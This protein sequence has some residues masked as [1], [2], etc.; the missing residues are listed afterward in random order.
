MFPIVVNDGQTAF[1]DDDIYYIICK[2]GVYLKKRLGVMESIAPVKNISILQSVNTMAKMHIR[3]IPAKTAQEIINFFKAVYKEHFSEAIVLLFY[4]Q[5]TKKHKIIC[6]VQEVSGAAADY[7]KGIVI[8][9]YDMIGTIH[10]HASMSAFHSGIDDKDEESFDG[11]H[12]TFGNIRDD[13]ISVSA[14]IVANG[15]RVMVDPRDYINQLELT[16]DIDENIQVPYSRTWKWD[17]TQNKMVEVSNN[18]FYTK[19]NYDQRYKIK[20]AKDPKFNPIWMER[21]TKKVYTTNWHKGWYGHNAHN[22]FYGDFDPDLWEGWHGHNVNR[23]V[24]LITSKPSIVPKPTIKDTIPAEDKKITAC[25]DCAFKHHKMNFILDKLNDESKKAVLEWALDELDSN[26]DYIMRE[27]IKDSDVELTHYHCVACNGRFSVDELEDDACCPTCGV[28]DYLDEITAS[29]MML[30]DV[31][32]VHSG[33]ISDEVET[34]MIY[35]NHCGSSFSKDFLS[36]GNTCPACNGIINPDQEISSEGYK[37]KQAGADSG[38][39]LDPDRE[40]IEQA[41]EADKDLEKIP[42]PGQE[43]IPIKVKRFGIFDKLLKRGKK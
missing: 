35:C 17:K 24:P 8:E 26:A 21:V 40:A 23:A 13:D 36:G 31:E 2:E 19:R 18:R 41:I 43:S 5:E 7:N 32:F 39:F 22:P 14:S 10:S 30:S 4:N 12:I 27:T 37:I 11:L 28:D 42:I 34:F 20:I 9:G 25:D 29:E 15:Y 3:K 38:T 1:P 6:P 33:H 16:V